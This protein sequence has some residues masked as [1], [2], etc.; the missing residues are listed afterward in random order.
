MIEKKLIFRKN[1]ANTIFLLLVIISLLFIFGMFFISYVTQVRGQTYTAGKTLQAYYLAEAAV[2]KALVEFRTVLNQSLLCEDGN[3]NEDIFLLLDHERAGNYHQRFFIEDGL[4][5]RSG[6]AEA[7]L[8]LGNIRRTSFGA[9]IDSYVQ[10]PQILEPYKRENMYDEPR[11][12][13]GGWEGEL[14]IT[15]T[16]NYRNTERNIEVIH[17]IRVSDI[18]PPAEKYT[19]FIEGENDEYI[20][21]GEFRLRN[22]SVNRDLQM[23]KND[24]AG[25]ITTAFHGIGGSPSEYI[26]EPTL[27]PNVSFEGTVKERVLTTVRNLV[28]ST[29]D[30]D[31]QDYVLATARTMSARRWGRVRTN[32][33]L[34]V[35][36]PFFAADD[37]INY[38]EE[39]SS[40]FIHQSPDIGY[41]FCNNQ[42]HDPYLSIYTTFEGEVIKYFK[43]LRPYVLDEIGIPYPSA[44][45]YTPGTRFNYLTTNPEHFSAR[46]LERIRNDAIIYCHEMVQG[47]LRLSG[48]YSLPINKSGLIYVSGRLAIGGRFS[49]RAMI[50]TEGD[51][52]LT[53]DVVYDSSDSFLSLVSL[54]GAVRFAG[55]L[56]KARLEAA[57]Y[58]LNSV[59]GGEEIDIMGNLVVQNLN[60]QIGEE[61][62]LLMPRRVRVTYDRNLKSDA[63][64]NITFNISE[65]IMT[66][67]DI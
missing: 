1:A 28:L 17:E 45:P 56:E 58:A 62:D 46:Q 27:S 39:Q 61:G 31:I 10:V 8:T 19:L 18:T 5:V 59:Q 29:S 54:N 20:R 37:I 44:E 55:G 26:W 60:R 35:Y 65:R 33:R 15:A 11:R 40:E 22:W 38:F 36:L 16:G 7:T 2:E 21:H 9:H 4:M 50:V 67:R 25:K 47:D 64:T 42:L 13:L 63:A 52:I 49:G 32:G 66:F 57:V 14:R 24:L 34:H 23:L 53:D 48:T 30:L 6:W 12:S 51:I 43:K 3:I 41:L